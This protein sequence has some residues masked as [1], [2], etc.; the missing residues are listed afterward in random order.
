MRASLDDIDTMV[1]QSKIIITAGDL[2]IDV[3]GATVEV[4]RS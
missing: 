2:E 4:D 1:T 3:S